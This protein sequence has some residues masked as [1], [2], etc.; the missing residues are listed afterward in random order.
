LKTSTLT[1]IGTWFIL[2]FRVNAHTG[3]WTRS[4]DST[5]VECV[6][7]THP[8]LPGWRCGTPPWRPPRAALS[9]PP[10]R[11]RHNMLSNLRRTAFNS[12]RRFN[13]APSEDLNGGFTVGFRS[14]DLKH[15]T[16]K[17]IYSKQGLVS[18]V[19]DTVPH[20]LTSPAATESGAPVH[21]ELAVSLSRKR[22]HGEML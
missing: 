8:P 11:T 17:Y 15:K 14:L 3:E 20:M 2:T 5:T 6:F 12:S 1:T 18:V 16:D 13:W 9:P 21:Y 22:E 4:V 10:C 7:R 19:K